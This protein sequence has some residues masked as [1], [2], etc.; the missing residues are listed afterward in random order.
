SAAPVDDSIDKRD[1]AVTAGTTSASSGAKF[2]PPTLIVD[3]P[4][5]ITSGTVI[6]TD[7]TITTNGITNFGKIYRGAGVDGPL[8]T[9]LG[10]T[11][12]PFDSV[13]FFNSSGGG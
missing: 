4:Y 6:N 12:I 13:D 9:W 11:P 3:D 5:H 2:G 8:A 7:P 1:Q 10:S